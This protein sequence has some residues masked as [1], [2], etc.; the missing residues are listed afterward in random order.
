MNDDLLKAFNKWLKK[1][2][3][4]FIYV[5]NNSKKLSRVQRNKKDLYA[6]FDFSVT[7]EFYMA[8]AISNWFSNKGLFAT[9]NED[10][11]IIEVKAIKK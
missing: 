2:R 9:F 7:D 3:F 5:F 6:D 1:L 11:S 4:L 10:G 8:M